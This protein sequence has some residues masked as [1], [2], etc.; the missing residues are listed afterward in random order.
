[1]LRAGGGR[2]YP[3]TYFVHMA[4]DEH[5]AA[6][7]RKCVRALR[8]RGSRA[9]ERSHPPLPLG[10]SRDSRSLACP[11]L[12]HLCTPSI[13]T[14]AGPTFFSARISGIDDALSGRLVGA[15]R[16]AGLLDGEGML[17]DWSRPFNFLS[18]LLPV[19]PPLFY[20]PWGH[21]PSLFFQA[22]SPTIR[23]AQRG[24]RRCEPCRASLPRCQASRRACLTRFAPTSLLSRR[25][26]NRV[27]NIHDAARD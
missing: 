9:A 7:V 6:A 1:M 17:T 22:C 26:V 10:P 18:L 15:L 12:L 11:A 4:R 13:H 20:P 27:Q 14:F 8:G 21:L 5:T 16:S 24:A 23:A 2:A 19:S 3:P 25:C